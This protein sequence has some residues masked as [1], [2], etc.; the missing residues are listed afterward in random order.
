MSQLNTLSP[1]DFYKEIETLHLKG[2][3]ISILEFESDYLSLDSSKLDFE[4]LK[5]LA[6]MFSRAYMKAV[7]DDKKFALIAQYKTSLSYEKYGGIDSDILNWK[8]NLEEALFMRYVKVNR[9]ILF[10]ILLAVLLENLDL[11]PSAYDFLP[12]LTAVAVV[13]YLLN[14]VMNCRVK[15]LYSK[16]MRLIYS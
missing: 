9:F 7:S 10:S 5:C 1:I 13:W 14:Y 2:M 4:K 11:L 15:R 3:Y 12:I 6:E 8:L 16:L